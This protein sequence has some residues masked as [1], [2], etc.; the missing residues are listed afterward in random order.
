MGLTYGEAAVTPGTRLNVLL[1][2]ARARMAA[3]R[4]W[5]AARVAEGVS[6]EQAMRELVEGLRPR[7]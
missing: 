3:N 1:V 4:G 6:A 5:V 7:S 2:E